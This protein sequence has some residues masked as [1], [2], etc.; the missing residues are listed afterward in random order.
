MLVYTC[1]LYTQL[2]S[3][4]AFG[5]TQ[6]SAPQLFEPQKLGMI[7]SLFNDDG[8]DGK[9]EDTSSELI[10]KVINSDAPERDS[11]EQAADQIP[12]EDTAGGT[13]S[14]ERVFELDADLTSASSAPSDLLEADSKKE[15]SSPKDSG[16]T[17]ESSKSNTAVI[18]PTT[19]PTSSSEI[20][21]APFVPE[22][23]AEVIRKSGL[24]YSAG[25]ALF[26]S[27]IFMLILGWFADLL[28]GSTPWGT[29]IG[30]ALGALIGF[31]QF[32]RITSQIIHPKP[33]DFERVSLRSAPDEDNSLGETSDSG[34]P[35]PAG[36]ADVQHQV[37]N[38]SASV[39]T[40]DSARPTNPDLEVSEAV[41]DQ[42]EN[43]PTDKEPA[44]DNPAF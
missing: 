21:V 7:K 8:T 6:R 19:E 10:P 27:V 4:L 18:A 20:K 12:S 29:L 24:A 1:L 42:D 22:S 23:N 25:I 17:I 38:Q 11:T 35:T 14:G 28:L 43:S 16:E 3:T 15:K 36:I 33:N 31:V 2:T 32:F 34:V 39:L 37:V 26:V 41:P 9:S 40:E 30:I 5:I 44:K 13:T